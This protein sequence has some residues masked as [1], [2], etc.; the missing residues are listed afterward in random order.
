MPRSWRAKW[1]Q[2]KPGTGPEGPEDRRW[3]L[4]DSLGNLTLL[5]Q[6]LNSELS[7]GPWADKRK[8]I[9]CH[10]TLFL[11]KDLLRH[12]SRDDQWDEEGIHVR[13]TRLHR[14]FVKAWPHFAEIG[15][16]G[17]AR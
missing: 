11:N 5:T 1:P 16:A 3:R 12:S 9:S 2:P 8:G 17:A 13:A 4:L 10:S 6:P 15:A 7:N 14:A